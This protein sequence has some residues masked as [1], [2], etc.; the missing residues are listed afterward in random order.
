MKSIDQF[1]KD[2]CDNCEPYLKLKKNREAVNE[3][4]SQ[5]FDGIASVVS[6]LL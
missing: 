6:I 1:V 3:C 2:G 5:N 4:T